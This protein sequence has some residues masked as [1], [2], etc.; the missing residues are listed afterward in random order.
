VRSRVIATLPLARSTQRSPIRFSTES[1]R[2]CRVLNGKAIR[3][4]QTML[5]APQATA[6]A[7]S[8]QYRVLLAGDS[9]AVV[10]CMTKAEWSGWAQAFGTFAA[11]LARSWLFSSRIAYR[12]A[13][14][15]PQ[16]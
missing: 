13:L 2:H 7:A 16:S 5:L 3:A 14:C 15:A 11:I 10:T 8:G 4:M 6:S 1:S 12:N 9:A